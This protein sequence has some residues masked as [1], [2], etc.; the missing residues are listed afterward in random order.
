MNGGWKKIFTKSIFKPKIPTKPK[1]DFLP[2]F[3][4]NKYRNKQKQPDDIPQRTG[5]CYMAHIII[6]I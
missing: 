4:Y 2:K 3:V 1:F 6:G 5:A